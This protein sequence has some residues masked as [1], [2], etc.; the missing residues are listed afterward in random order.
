MF[1]RS[2]IGFCG[3]A[4]LTWLGTF[5][6]FAEAT[7][8]GA[9]TGYVP[10]WLHQISQETSTLDPDP[11]LGFAGACLQNKVEFFASAHP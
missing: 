10:L 4:V 6:S 1:G 11:K 3:L 5:Q 7:R 8:F 9:L 2:L